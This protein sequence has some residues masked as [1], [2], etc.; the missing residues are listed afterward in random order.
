M[1][2]PVGCFS[3]MRASE[4]C[5]GVGYFSCV[6][7]FAPTVC[8][9]AHLARSVLLEKLNVPLCRLSV[10]FLVVGWSCVGGRVF[11][12]AVL[13]LALLINGIRNRGRLSRDTSDKLC[14]LVESIFKHGGSSSDAFF[15]LVH[16]ISAKF[17]DEQL[18][19]SDVFYDKERGISIFVGVIDIFG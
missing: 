12:V 19:R 14:G 5:G 10:V 3:L 18:G 7:W 1:C 4:I 11:V 15:V 16:C 6:M 8:A 17:L 9:C 2:P 13:L